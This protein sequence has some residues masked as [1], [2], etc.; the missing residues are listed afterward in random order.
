[1]ERIKASIIDDID[2]RL[3]EIALIK[4]IAIDPGFSEEKKQ[5]ALKYSIPALY[6][7]WEGF[8]HSSFSEYAKYLNDLELD[9]CS[10]NID[11]LTHNTFSSLQLHNPPREYQK[12]KDFVKRMY[13]FLFKKFVSTPIPTGS[14]VDYNQ[15][16]EICL[17]F[18]VPMVS[19]DEYKAKL[20]RFLMFRNKL[21]HGNKSILVH[22][23]DLELF[24]KLVTDLM[25]DVQEIIFSSIDNSS[26]KHNPI[27]E[28]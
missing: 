4:A 21:S 17:R 19:E 1:M 28:I 26:Y 11:I 23:S 9:F 25:F 14:N 16:K 8:V 20:Y 24:S 5:T 7:V 15:L 22:R 12:Q 18:G 6:S 13:D 2:W 3:G 10:I 27:D